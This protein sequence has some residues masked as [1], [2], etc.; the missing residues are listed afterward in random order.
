MEGLMRNKLR[1]FLVGVLSAMPCFLLVAAHAQTVTYG[2]ITF[3][4]N[5]PVG[6][7]G[8]FTSTNVSGQETEVVNLFT[9]E[10]GVRVEADGTDISYDDTIAFTFDLAPGWEITGM[11][12]SDNVDDSPANINT[13]AESDW[14]YELDQQVTL[15]SLNDVCSSA[16]QLQEAGGASLPP[17]SFG[18]QTGPGTGTFETVVNVDNGEIQTD[19][20]L[21]GL[22]VFLVQI[23][24]TPEPSSFVM[25]GTGLLGLAS[26]GGWR[27]KG[28]GIRRF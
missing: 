14:G 4:S 26:V 9:G 28:W 12:F 22:D 25:L 5:A 16:S 8:V 3:G 10:L 13:T 2:A 17:L 11:L 23:A 21:A 18:A 15:C 6:D 20:V 19:G 24:P 27:A 1:W 7:P